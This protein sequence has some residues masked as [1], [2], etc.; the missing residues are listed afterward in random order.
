M[1]Y[2]PLIQKCNELQNILNLKK[3]KKALLTEELSWFSSTNIESLFSSLEQKKIA[4]KEYKSL[5]TINEKEINTLTKNIQ[6]IKQYTKTLFNPLNWFDDEQK[7]YR[8]RLNG[9]KKDHCVSN[10]H[11]DKKIKT[12]SKIVSVISKINSDIKKYELFDKTKTHNEIDTLVREIIVLE[13]KLKRTSELK[14]N[15]DN[16]LRPIISQITE[17]DNSI[18]TANTKISMAKSI[19]RKLDAAEN[20]YERAM[21]HE[22]CET[23]FGDGSPK[24]VISQEERKIRQC[25]RDLIKARKRATEIRNKASREIR[26]IIIDGN[27]LCYEGNRFVGFK[28]LLVVTNE[29][30]SKYKVVVVFDSAIRAQIK[31]NDNIIRSNFSDDIEIH[32]VATKHLADETVLDIASNDEVCYVLSNDRFGE[33]RDKEVVTSNRLI[34]HEIVSGKV[35]VHDLNINSKYG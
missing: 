2:N 11:K 32:I 3:D 18:S 8:K 30:S 25:E 29:L 13:E 34:R 35:I 19:E 6:D 22:K 23:S 24:K 17:Y 7:S 9:L 15:V 20:S 14:N 16:A 21:I 1:E 33:Y 12:I 4:Q 26:K 31:A 5:L 27:N 10:E 28:A